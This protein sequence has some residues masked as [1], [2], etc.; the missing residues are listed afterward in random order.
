[1]FSNL[2]NNHKKDEVD[3]FRFKQSTLLSQLKASIS[4]H[5][6]EEYFSVI[7]TIDECLKVCQNDKVSTLK[8]VSTIKRLNSLIG[9]MIYDSRIA[10]TSEEERVWRE[11]K[12]ENNH[13]DNGGQGVAL[14]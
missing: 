10:L 14:F 11:L 13:Y 3:K 8:V 1:M 5:D 7:E 12:S 9:S 4:Q 6:G 2:F